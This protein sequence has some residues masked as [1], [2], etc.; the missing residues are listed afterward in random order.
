MPFPNVHSR[1]V[2]SSLAMAVCGM[3][4]IRTVR[5]CLSSMAMAIERF[6]KKE[7]KDQE[8]EGF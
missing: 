5:V 6:I 7:K 1:K 3:F 2:K 4:L 8:R